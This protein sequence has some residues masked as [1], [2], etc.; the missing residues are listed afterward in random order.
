MIKISAVVIT[1]NEEK[2]IRRCILS[3]KKVADE[4]IVVDSYSKDTT[5]DICITEG[6][7]FV[8]HVFEGHIQQKNF[9]MSLASNDF[10]LSLDADEYLS[11][12]LSGSIQH[13][14]KNPL[15]EAYSM[16]RVTSIA[17]RWI[18]STDWYPD[19]KLRLWNKAVGQ[20]GGYNPHD[21]VILN[22]SV[23]IAHLKGNL[24]HDGYES[25]NDLMIKANQYARI[26]A[27]ANQHKKSSSV[28]KV[29]YKTL[30]T[31]IRNYFI[32]YGFM[33]GFDGLVISV[34]N[35]WYTFFKYA[36]LRELQNTRKDK[37]DDSKKPE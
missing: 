24:M 13:V 12:E 29:L 9:A 32:K 25:Y 4:I 6:V 27:Q 26:F 16:N 34:T 15:Q 30:Y 18:Y 3:L 19:T 36:M 23:P 2:S 14:K 33:S 21:T 35:T 10:I 31:F 22:K 28:F 37:R 8:E 5:K 11:E 17:G 20:W 7:K 1:F